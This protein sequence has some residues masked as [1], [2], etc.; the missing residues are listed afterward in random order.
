[1]LKTQRFLFCNSKQSAPLPGGVAI[2]LQNELGTQAVH[3]ARPQSVSAELLHRS[4][5][6]M[7]GEATDL[8]VVPLRPPDR[9]RLRLLGGWCYPAASTGLRECRGPICE[10][11]A[12]VRRTSSYL[13]AFLTLASRST[14]SGRV[15]DYNGIDPNGRSSASGSV[16]SE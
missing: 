4:G 15:V 11:P 6:R 7:V 3:V 8:H 16:L 10:H 5:S 12:N 2:I 14:D 1:M 13:V 9:C